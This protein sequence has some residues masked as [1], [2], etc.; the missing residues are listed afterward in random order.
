MDVDGKWTTTATASFALA[1]GRASASHCLWC[2][3]FVSQSVSVMMA[4]ALAWFVALP[5]PV[6]FSGLV[7]L[8]EMEILLS[9]QIAEAYRRVR[10]EKYC[11][12]RSSLK[13]LLI[14]A[15]TF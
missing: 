7:G 12:R 14:V 5:P 2:S 15:Y 11:G 9:I 8:G 6:A 13:V 1:N 3:L 10:L 4:A